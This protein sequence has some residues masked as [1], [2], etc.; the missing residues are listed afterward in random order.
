MGYDPT[1]NE[2]TPRLNNC[3]PLLVGLPTATEIPLNLLAEISAVFSKTFVFLVF[4]AISDLARWL[5]YR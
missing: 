4:I 5:L 2:S 1:T 3:N